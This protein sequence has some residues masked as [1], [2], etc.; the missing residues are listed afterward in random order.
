MP[1]RKLLALFALFS[2]LLVAGAAYA[3]EPSQQ[4]PPSQPPPYQPQAQYTPTQ[5]FQLPPPRRRRYVEGEPIPVG[6]HLEEKPQQGLVTAGFIVLLIPYGIS[7]LTALAAK[8]SNES[9]W[10]YAPVAGPFLTIG[11]RE[12]GT[13]NKPGASDS[14][15]CL[16]DVF[17]V[18]GLIFDGIMQVTGATLLLA[19]YLNTKTELVRDERA[20]RILPTQVGTGYGM[21][22]RGGF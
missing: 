22:L 5:Q 15:R 3:Q 8:G 20:L 6:Y 19:G 9:T 7:A 1:P 12:Y 13:C 11:L 16:A 18:T 21:G 17:V 14:L 10:L 4:L 2:P